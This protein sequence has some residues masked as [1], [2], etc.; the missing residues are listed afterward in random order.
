MASL[1]I[2]DDRNEVVL[3]DEAKSTDALEDVLDSYMHENEMHADGGPGYVIKHDE[4]DNL[5]YLED[6][7]VH[8]GGLTARY[9]MRS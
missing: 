1:I 3:M 2:F 5:V 8:D 6:F 7:L 4:H 9:E